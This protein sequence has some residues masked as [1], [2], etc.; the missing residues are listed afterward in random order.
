MEAES[1][2]PAQPLILRRREA[3][4]EDAAIIVGWF[5][6]RRDAVWWG[7]PAVPDPLTAEWLVEEFALGFCWVW[8]D[9]DGAVLAMPGLRPL[10]GGVAWLNRFGI[11]P[12]LRGRGLAAQVMQDLIG[13]ARGRGDSQMSLGVYASNSIARRVYDRLGFRPVSERS[14]PEDAS[15]VSII[16]R[17]ELS[18]SGDVPYPP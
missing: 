8:T 13:I 15:G 9:G 3:R 17:L 11:A 18:P 1:E 6:S 10:E 16:M 14:A 4:P 2:E 5:P 12:V 7:G